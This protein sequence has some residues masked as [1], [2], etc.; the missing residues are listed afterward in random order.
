MRSIDPVKVGA[1]SDIASKRMHE[2]IQNF[3]TI[4]KYQTQKFWKF[5]I[6]IYPTPLERGTK[7]IKNL[8]IGRRV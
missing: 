7:E 4:P 8:K 5:L 1:F 2:V 6:Q 3:L